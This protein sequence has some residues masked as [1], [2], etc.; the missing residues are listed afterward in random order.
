MGVSLL[1]GQHLRHVSIL[2]TRQVTEAEKSPE[3]AGGSGGGGGGG[4]A[5]TTLLL[6][7]R[8]E[9]NTLANRLR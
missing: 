3:P 4:G 2:T 7:L 9:G 1:V 6:P 8:S 5:N